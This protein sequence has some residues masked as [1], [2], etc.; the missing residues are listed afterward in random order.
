GTHVVRVE[1]EQYVPLSRT[2]GVAAGKL[3]SLDWSMTPVPKKRVMH[4]DGAG[5]PDAPKSDFRP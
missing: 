1:A 3:T 2:V 5:L 4:R